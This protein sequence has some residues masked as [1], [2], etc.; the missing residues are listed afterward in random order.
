MVPQL[1]LDGQDGHACEREVGRM[2]VSK[3]VRVYASLQSGSPGQPG[4]KVAGVAR[5]GR[6]PLECTEQ[7]GPLPHGVWAMQLAM[8]DT[9]PAEPRRKSSS[10]RVGGPSSAAKDKRGLQVRVERRP[11]APPT[12]SDP[13]LSFLVPA[14]GSAEVDKEPFYV[15]LKVR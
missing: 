11:D 12:R 5:V 14:P 7:G 6:R 4:Q 15:S 13:R 10:H 8:F 3:P 1:L 9:P 2:R